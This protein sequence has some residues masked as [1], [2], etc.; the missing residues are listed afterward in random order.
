MRLTIDSESTPWRIVIPLVRYYLPALLAIGGLWLA[1]VLGL[2]WIWILLLPIAALGVFAA[3]NVVGDRIRD[4]YP[5]PRSRWRFWILPAAV[6]I[7][8]TLFLYQLVGEQW[9][10]LGAGSTL[11]VLVAGFWAESQASA[12]DEPNVTIPHLVLSLLAYLAT[13]LLYSAIFDTP[14]GAFVSA[15]L[16][17]VASFVMAIEIYRQGGADLVGSLP[18]AIVTALLM[19]QVAFALDY[20]PLAGMGGGIFLLLVFYAVTGIGQNYLAGRLTRNSV[21]EFLGIMLV[22]FLLLYVSRTWIF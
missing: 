14:I 13:F 6:L 21:F 19:G 12:A 22:G 20:W 9:L 5:S 8:S 16:V 2:P 18:H 10:W 17:T 15:G 4:S 1:V 11:A 7:S 3:D